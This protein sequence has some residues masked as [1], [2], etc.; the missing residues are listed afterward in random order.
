MASPTQIPPA[1]LLRLIGPPECP[2]IIDVRID[3]DFAEQPF[4]IPSA[5]RVDYR[6]MSEIAALLKNSK[7]VI[8]CKKGL[9]IGSGAAAILRTYGVAAES[10]SGGLFAWRD[11]SFPMIPASK[12][13]FT[14]AGQR[15]WVSK[16]R[17]KIDRIACPWLIKRFID[18]SAKF[19]FVPATQ[20]I[21]VGEQ[22][23]ATPFDVEDVYYSHR[24][25]NCTF[26]TLLSEF[27][28]KTEPLNRL[29]DIV[30][31]ADTNRLDLAPQCAGL[32]AISLGF[33]RIYRDDLAQLEASLPIYDALYRWCRDATSEKHDS[34]QKNS[35]AAAMERTDG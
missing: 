10:L 25:N 22:F 34:L 11:A 13:P 17:P 3:E 31:G 21:A 7:V 26:D 35:Q 23:N 14:Q 29:A 15:F 28:L 24:G 4:L 30:R 20:V 9:K 33:S 12:L 19:L 5:Y 18:P 32:L 8:Y 27:N 2:V 6:K 1:Q 16:A